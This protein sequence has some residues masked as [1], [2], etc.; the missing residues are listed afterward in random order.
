MYLSI[1]W[2]G[3]MY[4]LVFKISIYKI[5]FSRYFPPLLWGKSGHIQTIVYAKM[6]RVNTPLPKG[7]RFNILMHDGATVTFDVFEP[8]K[9][10]PT[11]GTFLLADAVLVHC[12][13]LL[14]EEAYASFTIYCLCNI[15]IFRLH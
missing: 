15:H 12:F 11:A 1:F 9:S 14:N 2:Y 7:E 5:L 13:Q 4:E 8:L 10:H 3:N 6:G